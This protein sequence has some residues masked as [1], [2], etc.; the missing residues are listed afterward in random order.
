MQ[1][2]QPATPRPTPP[3]EF[4][5]WWIIHSKFALAVS[6]GLAMLLGE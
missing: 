1:T 4:V 6:A 3:R 5:S 2:Q